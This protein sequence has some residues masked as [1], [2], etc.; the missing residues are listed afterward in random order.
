LNLIVSVGIT[1]SWIP[2]GKLSKT[3][4]IAPNDYVTLSKISKL[5]YT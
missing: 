3:E 5:H 4:F 1:V 2:I